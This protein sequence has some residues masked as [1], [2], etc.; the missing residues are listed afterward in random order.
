MTLELRVVMRIYA[1]E[2]KIESE[3]VVAIL[4]VL[5]LRS[6]YAAREIYPRYKRYSHARAL[7]LGMEYSSP[8]YLCLL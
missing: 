3:R 7:P 2:R 8:F 4:L 1:R 6:F 5:L